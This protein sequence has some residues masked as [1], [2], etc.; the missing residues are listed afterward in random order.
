M[1]LFH[2]TF[3]TP[4]RMVAFDAPEKRWDALHAL[5]RIAGPR[6]M[7]HALVDDHQHVVVRVKAGAEGRLARALLLGWRAI[8]AN[9][10]PADVR[11][12]ADRAHFRRLVD[13]LLQQPVKHG[14]AAHPATW[15]GSMF[16]D[17]VGARRIPGLS[18]QVQQI[19]PRYRQREAY[20]VVGLAPEPLVPASEEDVRAA[21][22]VR[23]SEL[24][25]ETFGTRLAMN[26][27]A[28]RRARLA[29]AT[30][31]AQAKIA[32][33]EIAHALGI[34]QQS[35]RRLRQAGP[36]AEADTRALRLRLALESVVHLTARMAS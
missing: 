9:L 4:D 2:L 23:L 35:T 6:S 1:R 13:Y 29:L 32:T 22:A 19:L 14:L 15:T 27:P 30:L 28:S 34:T 7:L 25:A 21:G 12:V 11:P 20:A 36:L 24:A 16:P 8:G 10:E 33:R 18:V 5:G 31:G 3:A 17:L 26:T